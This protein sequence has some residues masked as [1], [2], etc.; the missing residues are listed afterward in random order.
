MP[1][2][3][4]ILS[5][6]FYRDVVAATGDAILTIDC[7]GSITSWNRAAEALYGYSAEEMIG[8]PIALLAPGDNPAMR[9][10]FFQR[11]A[12]RG[13]P[14]RVEVR[15]RRKDGNMIDVELTLGT[16]R[17]PGGT[18]TGFVAIARDISERIAHQRR[19]QEL[20]E[21]YRTYFESM[22][23][24]TYIY[25]PDAAGPGE[26][27]LQ[28]SHQWGI[29]TGHPLHLQTNET[30]YVMTVV[31]PDDR[32]ILLR[33]TRQAELTGTPMVATY[34]IVT[35]DGEVRWVHDRANLVR[36][37]EDGQ[38][39]YWLG[40]IDDIT[41]VRTAALQMQETLAELATA[42]EALA[43]AL[44]QLEAANRDLALL[45]DAKSEF[46]SY[47][48]HEFRTPLTSIQGFSELILSDAETLDEAREFAALINQNAVMLARMVSNVLDLDQMEAGQ[49]HLH[50]APVDL[51]QV[52]ESA[53][54]LT[55]PT[56][57]HNLELDLNRDLPLILADK[58]ALVQIVTNLLSNAVK[59]TPT[60]GTITLTTRAEAD[61]ICLCVA[62]QG[63]GVPD[64]D[65]E[66]IFDRYGRIHR[67]EQIGI[68]GTG[69]GLPI[70][71]HLVEL[72]GGQIWVAPNEPT[73]SEFHVRIPRQGRTQ[74]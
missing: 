52:V 34:R 32:E 70:A 43:S 49:V 19:L 6:D 2:Q 57:H 1:N 41:D 29:V 73:G 33:S 53:V 69:L 14:V 59:Y 50:L 54:A 68:S 36:R 72:H 22:P 28:F 37:P 46:V 35:R 65:R 45:S 8:Q 15:R 31:H 66:R 21:R 67:P 39:V 44:G 25:T 10:A 51:N 18:V 38:P 4:D 74:R 5:P 56:V 11:L 61:D 63:I 40:H 23:G 27:T 17:D 24:L 12:A 71:R 64:A 7:H 13:E 26:G 48:S 3:N 9:T 60:G 47:I 55:A 16:V 42:N 20:E 30:S 58:D 62:D